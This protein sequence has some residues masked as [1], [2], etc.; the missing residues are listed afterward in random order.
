MMN[1]F[2]VLGSNL[3]GDSFSDGGND[4]HH[5]ESEMTVDSHTDSFF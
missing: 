2:L 5:K 3:S 4:Y 1:S